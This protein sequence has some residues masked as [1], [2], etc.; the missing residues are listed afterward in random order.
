MKRINEDLFAPNVAVTDENLS[1]NGIY[2]QTKLPSLGR[3]ICTVTDIH[4]PTVALFNIATTNHDGITILRN[5][6]EVFDYPDSVIK[7]KITAEAL[8]DIK[9]QHGED[10]LVRIANYLKGIANDDENAKTINFLKTNSVV[11]SN[12]SLSEPTMPDIV[13]REISYKVQQC[14]LEMNSQHIRTYDAFVVL[15]YSLGASIMSVFADLH[16]SELADRT[17]LFIG[18]SGLTDWY[19]NPDATDTEIYVGLK[20][21]L[22]T[23]RESAVFSPYVNEIRM[24]KDYETGNI[25]CFIWNRY[26]ITISP[27]HKTTEPMLMKFSVE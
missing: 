5:E 16:N 20:D 13:W 4:G 10:G 19:I 14:V 21:T 9:S 24:T 15:P 3:K 12:I 8:E 26:A 23:G 11:T 6:V 22:G 17:S 2:Q 1:I 27:L 18:K 25:V 7:T